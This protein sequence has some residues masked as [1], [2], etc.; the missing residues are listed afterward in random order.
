[1]RK[2]SIFLAALLY[3]SV[4]PIGAA[5]LVTKHHPALLK[6]GEF[7][8]C[9]NKCE[10]V[11]ARSASEISLPLMMNW[12]WNRLVDSLPVLSA[13]R[14]GAEDFERNDQ[15]CYRSIFKKLGS[16][17]EGPGEMI[18][19]GK[20]EGNAKSRREA[21]GVLIAAA[22]G[23]WG[24]GLRQEVVAEEASSSGAAT[25]GS[26]PARS[27]CS[28]VSTFTGLISCCISFGPVARSILASG[29]TGPI[30]RVCV[31]DVAHTGLQAERVVLLL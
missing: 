3:L 29:S 19:A 24:P 25:A 1:M 23:L 9:Q 12:R 8:G 31:L 20:V 2:T 10:S 5:F 18:K 16:A 6:N 28:C 30:C 22:V 26:L 27:D 4:V 21:F 11:F 15:G 7:L 14:N 17:A 13:C